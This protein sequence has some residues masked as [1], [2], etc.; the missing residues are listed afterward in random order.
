[1][2]DLLG[3]AVRRKNNLF[4]SIIQGVKGMEEFLL[5]RFFACDKMDIVYDEDI[6]VSVFLSETGC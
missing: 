4:V 5:G 2:G 6:D 3:R 1:M